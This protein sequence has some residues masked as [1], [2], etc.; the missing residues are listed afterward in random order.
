MII[1]INGIFNDLSCLHCEDERS[2]GLGLNTGRLR[3]EESVLTRNVVAM[4]GLHPQ[5]VDHKQVLA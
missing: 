5:C 3:H 2:L 1:M 4:V